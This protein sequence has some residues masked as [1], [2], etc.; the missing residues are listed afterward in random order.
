METKDIQNIL[1]KLKRDYTE[2]HERTEKKINDLIEKKKNEELAAKKADEEL[3]AKNRVEET[4][5]P[6]EVEKKVEVK[7]K[8]P[9]VVKSVKFEKKE[10]KE[11][12]EVKVVEV[13]D[14]STGYIIK[15]SDGKTVFKK[16]D[17]IEEKPVTREKKPFINRPLQTRPT[18]GSMNSSYMA[19]IPTV[20]KSQQKKTKNDSTKKFEDT[21]KTNIRDLMKRGYIIDE[22]KAVIRKS[23]KKKTSITTKPDN[24]RTCCYNSKSCSNKSIK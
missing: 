6:V 22:S 8:E 10:E 1:S 19:E 15:Y 9:E 17:K 5:I 11:P 13:Q 21:K 16:K 18:Q 23:K 2:L 14:R 4:E 12:N 3:L 7:E 20:T 24:Y